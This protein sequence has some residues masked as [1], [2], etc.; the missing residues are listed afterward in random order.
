M[1][2]YL[3]SRVYVT[4]AVLAILLASFVFSLSLF[5]GLSADAA[6]D[7][8]EI[9]SVEQMVAFSREM[10]SATGLGLRVE[11][12]A[13][14]DLSG[15]DFMP[16]GNSSYSF[17]GSFY[18]NDHTLTVSVDSTSGAAGVFRN[19][20]SR[21]LISGLTVKGFVRG[22][23]YVGG[24]VGD[25]DG[26]RI[27]KCISFV[28]VTGNNY[29]GGIAGSC[30]GTITSCSSFATVRARNTFGGVVGA[31]QGSRSSL[32]ES[33]FI[34]K[35]VSNNGTVFGG[36]A[37]SS[38]G[39]LKN[40]YAVPAFEGSLAVSYGS[41]VGTLSSTNNGVSYCYGVSEKD[42]V[43]SN[44]SGALPDTLSSK[45]T[46]DFLSG[47]V[48]FG[49][50]T[51]LAYPKFRIGFG[52]YPCPAY[53]LNN[54][55]SDFVAPY[56]DLC[57]DRFSV[58]L[59]ASGVG[60]V[61]EPFT[62]KTALQWD[63]FVRNSRLYDYANKK[64]VL[65]AAVSAGSVSSVGSVELPFAGVFDGQD[66]MLSFNCSSVEDNVGLFAAVNGATIR[67]VQLS[68]QVTG[69]DY[70]ALVAGRVAGE[71]NVF[72]DITVLEGS[73]ASGSSYVGA[74]VGGTETGASV[75]AT[76]CVTSASVFGN[77]YVGGVVGSGLGAITINDCVNNG[78]IT[79]GFN[80]GQY[81]GGVF[82]K[83]HGTIDLSELTNIGTIYA[84]G[85]TDV[86]GIGGSFGGGS[87]SLVSCVASVSGRFN[88]GG[89]FGSVAENTN[90][91][92]AA[93]AGKI[94]G[95]N[96]LGG[97]VGNLPP[98]LT[99]SVEDFYCVP[100]FE[101]DKAIALSEPFRAFCVVSPSIES[102]TGLSGAYEYIAS[103]DSFRPTVDAAPQT[104]KK[105]YRF[106]SVVTLHNVYYDSDVYLSYNTNGANACSTVSLT[107]GDRARFNATDAWKEV[108][109]TLSGGYYPVPAYADQTLFMTGYF[110]GGTGEEQDPIRISNE[111]QLRN[112][113]EFFNS[114]P[115]LVTGKYFLQTSDIVLKRTF[116]VVSYFNGTY[117]GQNYCI[118]DLRIESA[119]T[120]V[121]LFGT[122]SG[123]LKN[124]CVDGG[125]IVASS[126]GVVGGLVAAS[127]A[128]IV[129]CYVALD[130]VCENA[131]CCGGL[132]GIN[133]G[134]VS[135]SFYAGKILG[136]VCTGGLIGRNNGG[137]VSDVFTTGVLYG[138]QILGG[139]I[140]NNN[141]GRLS[142]ALTNV[143]A[144]LTQNAGT[145]S[146]GG[147]VG[148]NKAGATGGDTGR[149][150]ACL[151]NATLIFGSDVKK[152][153]LVGNLISGFIATG[154]VDGDGINDN[155]YYNI[156]YANGIGNDGMGT[157][158]NIILATS[159][160]AGGEEVRTFR[161]PH[162]TYNGLGVYNPAC[163][164][165]YAL[166]PTEIA[167]WAANV[168]RVNQYSARGAEMIMWKYDYSVD[169]TAY[170]RG[171]E[172][173]PYLI[174]VPA[175]LAFLCDSTR[176]T[177]YTGKYF[178]LT[179][180]LNMSGI[181][182]FTPIGFYGDFDSNYAFNG[183][184]DGQGHTI[185]NL[186]IDFYA[187]QNS[188]GYRDES[189]KYVALF[190]Y[191]GS[192][193]VL[194]RLVMD[195]SCRICGGQYTA[196]F[197]GFFNG[198][199]EEC[200][201]A[202]DLVSVTKAN[203]TSASYL[204]DS[205]LVWTSEGHY[206]LSSEPYSST[207]TYY[208]A[209]SD[210]GGFVGSLA[211]SGCR[212]T[213]SVFA[214][215]LPAVSGAYGFVG[216]TGTSLSLI[217]DNSWYLT[218]DDQ[219]SYENSYGR[220]LVDYTDETNGG[221][222]A[223]NND[224][225]GKGFYFTLTA[226]ANYYP[227][228]YNNNLDAL[229]YASS[230]RLV[231][232]TQVKYQIRYCQEVTF[233]VN[234]NLI[235]TETI[236]TAQGSVPTVDEKYYYYK[237]QAGRV[238]YTWKKHGYYLVDAVEVNGVVSSLAGGIMN[239]T[240]EE[241]IYSF[242]MGEAVTVFD[243]A[244]NV[245]EITD[246]VFKFTGSV[247]FDYNGEDHSVEYTVGG[248]FSVSVSYVNKA[249]NTR[250]DLH[251]AASYLAVASLRFDGDAT[252]IGKKEI[253]C[254]VLPKT[255]TISDR[256]DLAYLGQ[257]VY[258][259]SSASRVNL[260]DLSILTGVLTGDE[261]SLA[262]SVLVTWDSAD[263]GTNKT[264]SLTEFEVSLTGNYTFAPGYELTSLT[265][266]A[267]DRRRVV[268]AVSGTEPQTF[269]SAEYQVSTVVYS[270]K[271]PV[272]PSDAHVVSVG[273]TYTRM[274]VSG[275]DL[276]VDSSWSG[277]YDVGYY[278]M[279]PTLAD[280]TNHYLDLEGKTYLLHIVPYAVES[281]TL[282]YNKLKYTG[283]PL[284][285]SVTAYFAGVGEDGSRQNVSIAYYVRKADVTESTFGS[286]LFVRDE[287]GKTFV[288][289]TEY[290]STASY[291][292]TATLKKAGSYYA[293][294]RSLNDNYFVDA[295]IQEVTVAKATP[296][297]SL[298]FT[299]ECDGQTLADGDSVYY[300]DDIVIR[301]GDELSQKT[302]DAE[303]DAT[304]ALSFVS[305]PNGGDLT[306]YAQGDEWHIR[307]E[308]YGSQMSFRLISLSASDYENRVSETVFNLTVLPVRLYVG[309]THPEQI[310]GEV[311]DLSVT[312]YKNQ[313][314]TETIDPSE[315]NGLFPPIVS[316][317]ALTPDRVGEYQ[318]F[319]GGGSSYGYEFDRTIVPTLTIVPRPIYVSV[320][321][322][323]SNTKTYGGEDPTIRYYIY[324]DEA[325]TDK[326]TTLPDGRE[327]ALD[328]ALGREEGE[329]VGSYSINA[330]TITSP[331]VNKDYDL[332]FVSGRGKFVINYLDLR[333]KVKEG[334]NKYY[335]D[336][337]QPFELEVAEGYSLVNGD[338]I[339]D[340]L[341]G[342]HPIVT[343]AREEG[344]T[345]GSYP[346]IVT[347]DYVLAAEGNYN[348]LGVETPGLFY[349]NRVRPTISF[350][351]NGTVYFGD[352]T[353]QMNYGAARAYNNSDV[354]AGTFTW[355]QRTFDSM[356]PTV[357]TLN[358]TPKDTQDFNSASV[359]VVVIPQKRPVYPVFSGA[360]EYVYDG[361]AHNEIEV[362]LDNPVGNGEYSLQTN[363]SG[364]NRT[365]T[366]GG[367]VVTATLTS[368]YYVFADDA[369]VSVACKIA[370]A[371]L[372][373]KA[374]NV[375]VTEGESF[376]P[377]ITY[378]GFVGSES[379]NVLTTLATIKD[380]P[381]KSGVY[382]LTPQ[383]ASAKNYS[384]TYVS[385]V[386]TI[387]KLSAES[388]GIS[389]QGSFSPD[390]EVELN[391]V[392][393]GTHSFAD[394][395]SVL[396]KKLGSTMF[397]PLKRTLSS[398]YGIR[399]SGILE[400]E[401][402]Y[403]YTIELADELP[404]GAKLYV[405]DV[406]GDLVELTDYSIEEK[407]ITFFA[408]NVQGLVIYRNKTQEE[409]LKGYIP[410][411]AI[412]G[413]VVFLIILIG[414]IAYFKSKRGG[415][416]VYRAERATYRAF[417]HR[418]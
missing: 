14:L 218:T 195:S 285:S 121:G 393:E 46:Y 53:L 177:D 414:I 366:K 381:T 282:V 123:T 171:S 356:N 212:I 55:K 228:I 247:S 294:C 211:T 290:S 147:L 216:V 260:A 398:Y 312:Y 96:A 318:L 43:G 213:G 304:Y 23:N 75:T 13:D 115:T 208:T 311:I 384:F 341:T 151:S 185:K 16:I 279:D 193:F 106:V 145:C 305:R 132:V 131:S 56:S 403:S 150:L 273:W 303:Y 317:G 272:A 41:V 109:P 207:T 51:A 251:N 139:V 144:E 308:E 84:P 296:S 224:W 386:L 80:G 326:I 387:N 404:E 59:F 86:G 62:V 274:D 287:R 104:G 254:E 363:V 344:E 130:I 133:E 138:S 373:V 35:I 330:G 364:D 47:S 243:I 402:E 395:Q 397:T 9:S 232:N 231:S 37:G 340:F 262:V 313:Y 385:G 358:F 234:N 310:F 175:E 372:I 236:L 371:M 146:I 320:P 38:M 100:T 199:I 244:V 223:V 382:T 127:N 233:T 368:D 67:N 417:P 19:T 178:V 190:G 117:D 283:S 166:R 172:N 111:K 257:K 112:F 120:N 226:N 389:V 350:E 137:V 116:P 314:R 325:C 176:Y 321:A 12:K 129:R 263:S 196:S 271:S 380:I 241:M 58:C 92:S 135:T 33:V 396:D 229:A 394:M 352:T 367:F 149:I 302:A 107:D 28:D 268:V 246:S 54:D 5:S 57:A 359:S 40:N 249:S 20:G 309:I 293:V 31:L 225:D 76:G 357:V 334:Q 71:E 239:G 160:V 253:D 360:I 87:L 323:I 97:A 374:N 202:C 142:Y 275:G 30:K 39:E 201:S 221:A 17:E 10:Q 85:C 152:G 416:S 331:S 355:S 300:T 2:K 158:T 141:A 6:D 192:D 277:K 66:N 299:L 289:A 390:V 18:G 95:V 227:F 408:G 125:G 406:N 409:F 157:T 292:V 191:T 36:L 94:T 168:Y 136:G 8:V 342:D 281:V 215:S 74:I 401:A 182:M 256:A 258:D 163:D 413:G 179:N 327:I 365:V 119:E 353:D 181:E 159:V 248:G 3:F 261:E 219:Y 15:T 90:I 339:S 375:V 113:A 108:A 345:V 297:Q 259:G 189:N 286:G 91:V 265:G 280:E 206:V 415:K 252:I 65:G 155:S 319:Y 237:G 306:C 203:V 68:G 32:Q 64:V 128:E 1:K 399:F 264:Y 79:D 278:R 186:T 25:A 187:Y 118:S 238:T 81:V 4:F 148:E 103:D 333:L 222:V 322:A 45:T 169:L 298:V 180:D 210:V 89:L 49:D 34:G 77:N 44:S 288:E 369:I 220:V 24:I 73:V 143:I 93:Y 348:L 337:D 110:A 50:D 83:L 194:K 391:E 383:G 22:N 335:G 11:L 99:L 411:A 284:T 174:S 60:S 156:D 154:D 328:G 291:Y 351:F 153:G 61:T 197:V 329:N 245:A 267:I 170:P 412:A 324:S 346:Y 315:I 392:K 162:F 21:C 48:L 126:S 72:T 42:P 82:G 134:N 410:I 354:V 343:I 167:E 270:G 266:G 400:E 183:R 361:K 362:A 29:V 255:L 378:E 140:G 295:D 376:L 235:G 27:E 102:A 165:R 200:Y 164:A 316:T 69:S 70:V 114:Y 26:G 242:V 230:Y 88:V 78:V 214:G 240:E 217:T 7:V 336:M 379:K 301:F 184:F 101:K 307:P 377:E 418:K 349:I 52:Y 98:S 122:A 173:N 188:A 332:V 276:V 198:K 269:G 407:E 63:L 124:I 161:L 209:A 338:L 405:C 388:D 204:P 105:Y 370:P 250:T 205:Y 347:V